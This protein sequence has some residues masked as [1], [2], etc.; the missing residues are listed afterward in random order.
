MIEIG[1]LRFKRNAALI[2][3]GAILA[4]IV[5]ALFVILGA[6]L[7]ET[8]FAK[9]FAILGSQLVVTWIFTLAVISYAQHLY[10]EKTPGIS[11]TEGERGQLDLEIDWPIIR[12]YFWI[13][14]VGDIG[15]FIVLLTA[16]RDSLLIGIPVFTLWSMLTGAELALSLMSVD[17]NL[18]SRVLGI[19]AVLTF[20]SALIAIYSS[21]DLSFLGSLLFIALLGL[22]AAT[23]LR[24]FVLI[25]SWVQRV[26]SFLGSAIFVGYLFFDFNR[27]AKLSEHPR[28]NTWPVAMDV[29][30]AVYLDIINLFLLL[31]DILSD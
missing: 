28:A 14:F 4:G 18:G 27:L 1:V 5:L 2:I 20:T 26:I 24:L 19:T 8:L 10:Y 11:A 9:T 13:I 12:P 15:L 6:P 21:L 29:A 3:G 17:E 16:G 30:I 7:F 31:L 23:T 25:E 22:L